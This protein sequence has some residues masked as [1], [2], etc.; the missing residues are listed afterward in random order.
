MA[1]AAAGGGALLVVPIEGLEAVPGAA[2]VVVGRVVVVLVDDERDAREEGVERPVGAS[3]AVR[4]VGGL[5]TT[6]VVEEASDALEVGLPGDRR[7]APGTVGALRTVGLLFS[8]PDVTDE[9]SGSASDEAVLLA[10]A[11]LLA[12]VPGTGRVGGL[13]KL[14]P[15][16]LAREVTLDVGFDAVVDVREVVDDAAGRRAPTV[17]VPPVVV[18][19]RGGTGSLEVVE[20]EVELILR[21]TDEL[22]VEGAGNLF[23]CGLL[24]PVTVA[25]EVASAV[26]SAPCAPAALLLAVGA[27]IY[28]ATRDGL[29]IHEKRNKKCCPRVVVWWSREKHRH[30]EMDAPALLH[31]RVTTI[32]RHIM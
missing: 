22:G 8:S 7:A 18:G 32:G 15:A 9:R 29:L 20:A 2:L 14:D 31:H 24:G 3:P 1:S 27:S 23:L 11:A 21:R 16:V 19:R 12:A 17:A 26:L 25:L 6:A 5:L 4:V 30:W 28:K 13:F 10:T